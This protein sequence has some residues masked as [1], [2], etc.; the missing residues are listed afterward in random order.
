MFEGPY[1]GDRTVT[2]FRPFR[3]GRPHAQFDNISSHSG[4]DRHSEHHGFLSLAPPERALS[5]VG[6]GG[7]RAWSDRQIDNIACRGLDIL[8]SLVGLLLLAPL[9]IGLVIAVRLTSPGAAIFSQKRYGRDGRL[10]KVYKFRSMRTD[11]Q[12]L[13]G[14]CQTV[15]DDPRITPL[16]KFMR[17]TSFDELPQLFNVL[18]GDMSLVGPRPHV[19]FMLANGVPYEDFDPRY[20]ARHQVRPGI[21]GLAQINGYRGETDTEH[22]ARMRLE[23]DL[24]YIDTRSVRLNIAIIFATIRHEFFQGS[25]Y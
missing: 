13:S 16:G 24:D 11:L 5:G 15:R 25:G 2:L 17:K 21:T 1:W 7:D 18:I 6:R 19:P 22:A 4:I 12:D 3:K 8:G 20:M 9:L 10:F 14:T 23:Y